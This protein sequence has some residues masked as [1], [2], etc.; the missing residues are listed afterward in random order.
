VERGKQHAQYA[1]AI[2]ATLAQLGA[3]DEIL[4]PA[5]NVHA[6]FFAGVV[7]VHVWWWFYPWV[8]MMMVPVLFWL[9]FLAILIFFVLPQLLE[10]FE[11]GALSYNKVRHPLCFSS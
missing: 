10:R 1:K 3:L 11:E 2:E 6:Y 7:S 8:V 4:K 9:L 5:Q